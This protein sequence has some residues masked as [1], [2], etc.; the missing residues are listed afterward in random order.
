[1]NLSD[2]HLPIRPVLLLAA[3]YL[4]LA[5]AT[6]GPL[7]V[8]VA[9][10]ETVVRDASFELRT[11]PWQT[12]QGIQV[13][14]FTPESGRAPEGS[15]L[16][17]REFSLTRAGD[18]NF[19]VAGS[20][21]VSVSIDGQPVF[22]RD[23][24]AGTPV[25]EYAYDRFRWPASFAVAL[26]TGSH[27]ISVEIIPASGAARFFLQ[28]CDE[29]GAMDTRVRFS[30]AADWSIAGPLANGATLSPD[31]WRAPER[32]RFED[33]VLNPDAA[34]DRHSLVEWHYATG[35]THLAIL[36]AA[37]ASGDA[38]LRAHVERLVAFTLDRLPAHRRQFEQLH[39][40]RGASYRVFRGCLLDDTSA[41]ALPYI[42]LVRRGELPA[43]V[44][45]LDDI[46]QFV[47]KRHPRLADGTLSRDEPE[48]D[49]VWAD[50]LF[51][52]ASFLVR[53]A[54]WKKDAR[55]WDEVV[56]QVEG[57]HR[58][59][60]NESTG[61]Y[62]H[63]HYAA[64]NAHAAF[65]WGRANGWMAWAMS[66]VLRFLPKDHPGR[67]QVLELHR[68]HLTVLLKHQAASGLWHQVL[69]KPESYEETSASAM[70]LIAISR[71]LQAGWLDQALFAGPA[72]QAWAGLQT[73][74]DD[75]G[76]V[77]GICR[78]T[79]IGDTMEYYFQRPTMAHDPRGVGAYISA[80]LAA[81]QLPAGVPKAQRRD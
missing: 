11:M 70:F 45:L 67:A 13:L 4:S 1:M 17:R 80:A 10:S 48:P 23:F 29:H 46:L 61:L 52:S 37:D 63:G 41:P 6:D 57:F 50:D 36:E 15:C 58:H 38:T 43:A 33:F 42:E 39:A 47:L 77:Q 49:T 30:D 79:G 69:D 20:G 53:A 12:T 18:V 22:R 73:R 72:R 35:V 32:P 2:S 65:H 14:D 66:E 28:A 54:D 74:I 27:Q 25:V 34:F 16:A 78:G 3:S 60:V 21:R 9:A 44:P 31:D 55:I 76:V 40:W 64:R 56:R 7:R 26:G 62:W 24:G 75:R 51:M 71:G 59:L 68:R 5:G 81:M 19:G 8:A